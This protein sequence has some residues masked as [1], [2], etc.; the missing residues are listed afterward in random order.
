MLFAFYNPNRERP[1][2]GRKRYDSYQFR[3]ALSSRA[4]ALR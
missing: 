2:W 1:Q 3:P 4:I